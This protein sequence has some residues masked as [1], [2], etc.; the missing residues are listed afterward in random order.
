MFGVVEHSRPETG[1]REMIFRTQCWIGTQMGINFKPHKLEV[2][3]QEILVALTHIMDSPGGMV[4]LNFCWQ[5]QLGG[6]FLAPVEALHKTV[7]GMFVHIWHWRQSKVGVQKTSVARTD[8]VENFPRA[9]TKRIG[10][11][12]FRGGSFVLEV[13][14]STMEVVLLAW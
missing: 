6:Q 11:A 4:S 9:T 1:V 12:Y 5:N 2:R 14:A 13:D 8:V 10:V 7:V 3:N